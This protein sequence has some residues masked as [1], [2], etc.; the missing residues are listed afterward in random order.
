MITLGYYFFYKSVSWDFYHSWWFMVN[1]C[2]LGWVV[3]P[4]GCQKFNDV[5]GEI[6]L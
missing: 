3:Y 1:W 5:L 6:L 2:P 4:V